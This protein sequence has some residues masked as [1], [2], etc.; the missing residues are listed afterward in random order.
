MRVP[1]QKPAC[2]PTASPPS[3]T[4]TPVVHDCSYNIEKNELTETKPR[5]NYGDARVVLNGGRLVF[6]FEETRLLKAVNLAF[7][8]PVTVVVISESQSKH[9]LK[10]APA[11]GGQPRYVPFVPAIEGVTSVAIRAESNITLPDI[12]FVEIIACAQGIQSFLFHLLAR[13]QINVFSRIDNCGDSEA[14]S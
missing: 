6:T 7:K 9:K 8:V 10:V 13:M 14:N 12:L 5:K 2:P 1:C 4:T 3:P 11:S